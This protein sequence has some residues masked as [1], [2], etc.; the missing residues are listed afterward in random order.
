M[1]LHRTSDHY[2]A[3]ARRPVNSRERYPNLSMQYLKEK[4]V[5][6]RIQP[7]L[8]N[9]FVRFLSPALQATGCHKRQKQRRERRRKQDLETVAEE[10]R[11]QLTAP[12]T[13]LVMR[14]VICTA[15]QPGMLRHRDDLPPPVCV[16]ARSPRK[17]PSSSTMCSITS[18]APVRSKIPAAGNVACIHLH[19]FDFRRQTLSRMSQPSGMEFRADQ[20]APRC[21][22]WPTR[23]VPQPVPQP[24]SRNR[25]ASGKNL[26]AR[27]TMSSLRVTNQK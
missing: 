16:A 27:P 20:T 25:R 2:A 15:P 7:Q 5:K 23:E 8:V 18:N 22:I 11:F 24:I 17:T 14:D 19:E 26:F 13:P 6:S 4:P 1:N 10:L 21:A 3:A 12:I 9:V